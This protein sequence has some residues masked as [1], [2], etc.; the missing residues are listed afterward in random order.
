MLKEYHLW[1]RNCTML[2]F[3]LVRA[4]NEFSEAVRVYLRP[5]F[6]IRQ[7]QFCVHDFMGMMGGSLTETWH[8]PGRYF[9]EEELALPLKDDQVEGTEIASSKS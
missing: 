6:F 3:N 7:G 8:I 9:S 4:L 1:D 2:L 5:T